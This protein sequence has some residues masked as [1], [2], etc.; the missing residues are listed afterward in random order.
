MPEVTDN[1]QVYGVT[2]AGY[3]ATYSY[4]LSSADV[5]AILE[6]SATPER[7]AGDFSAVLDWRLVECSST[8]ELIR[9]NLGRRIDTYRTLRGFRAGM[10]PRRFYRLANR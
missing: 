3:R 10:S 2:W 9:P 4:S 6:G 5:A 1:L 7:F 8:Y